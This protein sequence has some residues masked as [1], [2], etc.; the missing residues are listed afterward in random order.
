MANRASILPSGRTRR[1]GLPGADQAIARRSRNAGVVTMGQVN[2]R[3]TS[4]RDIGPRSNA[5]QRIYRA[6]LIESS[7]GGDT[8]QRA[9]G[10]AISCS[11]RAGLLY[12]IAPHGVFARRIAKPTKSEA[13]P[14]SR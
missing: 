11:S 10:A 8:R 1:S 9:V 2:L 5:H 12:P 6:A 7:P 13:S 4:S 3:R 14:S